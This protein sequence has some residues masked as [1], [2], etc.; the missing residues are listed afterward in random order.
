MTYRD[1][2]YYRLTLDENG[3]ESIQD[4]ASQDEARSAWY[5]AQRRSGVFSAEVA[6]RS[7]DIPDLNKLLH[8]W[9]RKPAAR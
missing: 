1:P 4:F 5:A 6:K 9:E 7:H 3:Q 8:I 2:R